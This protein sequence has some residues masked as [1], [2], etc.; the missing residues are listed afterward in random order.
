MTRISVSVAAEQ[1]RRRV[2]GGIGTY[3]R[4]LLMGM[5]EL[6]E[7]ERPSITIVASRAPAGPDP[8]KDLGDRLVCSRLPGPL[9][10]RA[11]DLGLTRVG[12]GTDVVHSVSLA[13]PVPASGLPLVMTVHDV[14]W[15]SMPEAYPAR[16]RRWHEA[17]LRRAASRAAFVIAPSQATA[18]A[19]LAADVGIADKRVVVVN[20]GSDHLGEPDAE[21]AQSLLERLGVSGPYLLTVS[22]LEPR[23]NLARLI[24]AYGIAR[25]R[26]AEPWPLV[27]VGPTGWGP[28]VE[29]AALGSTAGVV[30][31]GAVDGGVLAAIYSGARCS[32][33]VPILEGFGLPVVESMAQGTPV[34]SSPVPSSGG[35]SLEIDPMSVASIAEGLVAAAGDEATRA[36]LV[37]SGLARAAGL[38]WVET[39]RAHVAV[40]QLALDETRASR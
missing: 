7:A 30:F 21:A 34:V 23:K 31:A 2:P 14:A 13:A 15:R 17:A 1:L 8:L 5:S 22:T 25:P 39:A 3:A 9:M 40:W 26:L 35:A 4:G 20:E 12:R 27:V 16:G 37:K 19:V 6:S 36:A 38:R 29:P 32:A 33:Y 24:E 11:W 10:T 28:S 18:E